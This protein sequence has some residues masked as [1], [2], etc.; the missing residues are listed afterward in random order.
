MKIKHG[1]Y[2]DS[3]LYYAK[4]DPIE[5]DWPISSMTAGNLFNTKKEAINH[6][7]VQEELIIELG[8]HLADS[9]NNFII[10]TIKGM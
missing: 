5:D 3:L 7:K 2:F 1:W 10:D 4:E 9:K 6:Y 8:R